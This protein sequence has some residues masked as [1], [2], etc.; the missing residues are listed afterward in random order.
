MAKLLVGVDGWHDL[1]SKGSAGA[2]AS[3]E[4]DRVGEVVPRVVNV[5]EERENPDGSKRVCVALEDQ[6]MPYGW[7]TPVTSIRGENLKIIGRP[8]MEVAV[9]KPLQAR[10]EFELSSAR[11]GEVCARACVTSAAY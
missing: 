8:L 6:F 3:G 10:D 9:A 1:C 7:I 2:L 4:F 11:A 5:I